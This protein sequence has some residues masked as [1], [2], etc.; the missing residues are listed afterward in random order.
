MK[1]GVTGETIEALRCLLFHGDGGHIGGQNCIESMEAAA[2][3][4]PIWSPS[5]WIKKTNFNLDDPLPVVLH[6]HTLWKIGGV[7][8]QCFSYGHT[9]NVLLVGGNLASC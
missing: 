1:W 7:W 6:G 5:S 4:S 2:A 8:M 3:R 9:S